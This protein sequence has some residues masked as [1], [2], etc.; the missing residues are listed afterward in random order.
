MGEEDINVHDQWAVES[1]GAIQDRTR[2]HLGTSD[3]VIMANRR[4]L[5]KAIE[6]VQAGGVAA[7]RCR[8]GAGR[9]RCAAPTRWTA[10]RQPASGP[11]GGANRPGQ[12]RRRHR[13]SSNRRP[14]RV[15]TNDEFCRPL[16]HPRRRARS[17]AAATRADRRAGLELVRFAWCDVHGVTRGKTLV[18][19]AAEKAMLGGVGMVSTLM[20][21]DTSDRT[22]F[23]VFEPGGTRPPARI[24][25]GQ[26]PAAA[27]RPGQLQ[28]TAMDADKTAGCSA[29]PG[30][31][32]ARRWS[33][34]RA[35]CS[36]RALARLADSAGLAMQCG[37]EV[38]FHIYRI[39]DDPR[40]D[41]PHR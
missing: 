21:K 5:L 10:W 22:A 33:W 29:S 26:Q 17:G 38:E 32:T 14:C 11:P 40:A 12:A 2:E 19:A 39:N 20:L 41:G 13:G 9:V 16:R 24:W 1:M 8:P 28:A 4:M 6:T 18:A 36:Q 34:T 37:L 31:R 35:A 25:P 15:A 3:K 30:S 23:K 27:G 7:R